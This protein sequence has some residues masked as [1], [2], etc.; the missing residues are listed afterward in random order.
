MNLRKTN[1]TDKALPLLPMETV[2]SVNLRMTNI[3]VRAQLSMQME[4]NT[5]ENINMEKGMVRV[6]IPMPLGTSTLVLGR[7][8]KTTVRVPIPTLMVILRKAFSKT[9]NFYMPK[10]LLQVKRALQK[11]KTRDCVNKMLALKSSN[12]P[13]PRR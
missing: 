9:V 10:K 12:N 13:N 1:I 7:M 8:L 11:K 5:L 6:P 3:V 2:T 4:T